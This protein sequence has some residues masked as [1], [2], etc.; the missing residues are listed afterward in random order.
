MSETF[1]PKPWGDLMGTTY[2]QEASKEQL[3]AWIKAISVSYSEDCSIASAIAAHNNE[4]LLLGSDSNL[5]RLAEKY[6]STTT[7]LE[8]FWREQR[9][10]WKFGEFTPYHDIGLVVWRAKQLEMLE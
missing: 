10:M 8:V 6:K 4:D 7:L 9:G 5:A 2:W 1:V 3:W